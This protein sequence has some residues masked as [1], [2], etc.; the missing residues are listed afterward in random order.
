[1]GKWSVAEDKTLKKAVEELGG[2]QWERI[3]LEFFAGRHTHV[4]CQV[5]WNKVIKPGLVK[6]PWKAEEDQIILRC[7]SEGITKW[8]EIAERIPGRIGKQCRERYF[9]HLDRTCLHARRSCAC[10]LCARATRACM[11]THRRLRA[12]THAYLLQRPSTRTRGRWKRIPSWSASRRV[13]VIGGVKS[14]SACRAAVK[15][16]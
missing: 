15:T 2:G 8:S 11:G 6:G 16:A 1:M 4:Q 5:R 7:L 13:L 3:A 9:N 14:Q 12:R 10:S